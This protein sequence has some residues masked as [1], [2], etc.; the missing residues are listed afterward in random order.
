MSSY[1]QNG[2]DAEDRDR[3]LSG[4]SK[5]AA[6]EPLAESG[7]GS[8]GH[9]RMTMSR[10]GGRWWVSLL[11]DLVLLAVVTGLVVGFIFAFRAVREL[12]APTWEVRSVVFCVKMEGISPDMVKYDR[13][14]G[15]YTIVSNPIWS[16]EFTDADHLG[17]VTDVR[18]VLVST[19]EVNTVTLYLKVEADAY[20]REGKGYRM[21][22]TLILA[23][24]EGTYRLEGLTAEGIIISMHEQ[25]EDGAA[26]VSWTDRFEQGGQNFDAQG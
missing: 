8:R 16:S 5:R 11:V 9:G 6:A 23:G 17:T 7:K 26:Q 25:S 10:R 24:A 13:E 20:Y 12:Y 22:E 1:Y 15:Q 18:T 2:G 4:L 21:G 14:K 19:G 3:K